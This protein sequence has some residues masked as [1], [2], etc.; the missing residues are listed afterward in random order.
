[1]QLFRRNP[2][3]GHG[4]RQGGSRVVAGERHRTPRSSDSGRRRCAWQREVRIRLLY[5]SLA[6][7][8]APVSAQPVVD[9]AGR[10]VE[11]P[12]RI[13][14]PFGA[15]PPVTA[16]LYAL[17]PQRVIALNMPF[18]PGSESYL[19]SGTT[20]LP[21][22]GSA[23]GHGRQVNPEVLLQL[24]PDVALA[25]RNSFSDLDPAGIE[26]PF[27]KAGIPVL[28]IQL[29]KL[30]DW[31]A[32]FEFVGKLIGREA[33]GR[34]LADYIREAQSR[35]DDALS[36]LPE[37]ERVSV[38]YAEMP[39]GL[40]SDCHT[41]FHTEA[42]ELARGYN[43]YRCQPRSMVGQERI[44][45]EQVALWD[46]QFIVAQDQLFL[47]RARR[48]ARWT[49]LSAFRNDR[50]LD[51]PRKPMNWLD[52]PPS[53]MRALGSQ[54]LAHAFYPQRFSLDIAAETRRFYRLFFDIELTDAQLH[55]LL[56]TSTTESGATP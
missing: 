35:I 53:F 1:M 44:G 52:R 6:L 19:Q 39:D 22:V 34:L 17:D 13:E 41:S 54:W 45:M 30:S 11:V 16:L 27:R 56:G 2:V 37:A 8:S 48:E 33:R 7:L 51:V 3:P 10:T 4:N 38:Y 42:I 24:R 31:P 40:A 25:W 21:V 47:N 20:T 50:V 55:E 32:A 23:M 43:L 46:P 5:I 9:M 29:D 26:T 49:R 12:E 28:Y 18:T 15:A 36:D 14:R